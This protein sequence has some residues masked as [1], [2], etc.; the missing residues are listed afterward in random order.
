[1]STL[2]DYDSAKVYLK[3]SITLKENLLKKDD[4]QLARGY[5]NYGRFLQILG[6]QYG[7]LEYQDK[8][9]N[10]YISRYGNEYFGLASIYYNKGSTYIL[11]NIMIKHSIIMK[12]L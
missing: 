4:P 10:I 9:E 3:N 2:S 8:A 6:D 7:A 12:G 1:M 11:L 5:L